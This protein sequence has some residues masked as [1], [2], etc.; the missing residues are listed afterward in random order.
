MAVG[1]PPPAAAPARLRD[2]VDT[3]RAVRAA[4]GRLDKRARMAELFAALPPGD[5]ALAASYLAGEI[6]QGRVGVGWAQIV[7]AEQRR[8]GETAVGET[9][10]LFGAADGSEGGAGG[11]AGVGGGPSA[12]GDAGPLTLGEVDRVLGEI[13]RV[14]G[15]GAARRRA[16]KLAGLMARA[17]PEEREF[18]G[19]LLV[20][21]LRQGALRALV[22][23]GLAAAL[24]VDGEAL[25]RACMF[26]PSPGAVAEAVQREGAA[27]LAR[28]GVAPLVPVEP[29]LAASAATV[30]EALADMAA[31]VAKAADEAA[32]VAKVA[33]GAAEVAA[34]L[35]KVAD[36]A[37]EVAAEQAIEVPKVADGAAEVA[38][39]A[40]AEVAAAV[41][42]EWKLDG[43]RIQLHRAGD[44]VRVFTRSLRDV[45]QAVPEL[46]ALARALDAETFIL[47]GEVVAV[48][49]AGRPLPFQDLMSRFTNEA[50]EK[51]PLRALFFDVLYLDGVSLL[52]RPYRLRRA[53]LE[54][55][56]EPRQTV[57]QRVVADPAAAKAAFDEALAAGHEG[58]VVKALGAPYAAGRRG[59]H[60]R[61]V[62]PSVTL[63]LVVLAVE[64]GHGRRR[65]LLSNL[66]LGARVPA[67][68]PGESDRF[69]MLGK[70]FKGLTDEML[71]AQ[72]DDLLALAVDKGE[73]VVRVRPER[74]VE[75]AFDE[76][77]RSPRYDS[78]LALRFARVKRYRPD[79]RAAEA[80]TLDEI[81]AIFERKRGGA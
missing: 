41:A 12:G 75:I 79:K 38:I 36:G 35:A 66:H 78:G 59:A 16:A 49:A 47:D 56:C 7:Q 44:E 53:A 32:A 73:H 69:A 10:S 68:A 40:A 65:G 42:I 20:G 17:T 50:G 24:G 48:D 34:E 19:A 39:E 1:E 67:A 30:E 74:V 25:R 72:T 63:D 11:G 37:A 58:V 9:L 21:E 22:I 5:L 8:N 33:D 4:P 60:W 18:L 6:P 26:A 43:V 77:Q 76:V 80:T 52:E 13:Q 62:K 23:E 15:A 3:S 70:T 57:W 81:K 27:A 29:M 45:T 2:V 46:V 64:W 61:K 54:H 28:F 55:L 71:R 31:G 51:T 14:A